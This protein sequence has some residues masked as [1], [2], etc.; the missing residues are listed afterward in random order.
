MSKRILFIV[1]GVLCVMGAKAQTIDIKS[2]EEYSPFVFGHNLEH[3]RAAVN[4]GLSAQMLQNR[5][6]AGKPS[7][8]QGVAG[9]WTGIGGKVFFQQGGHAYTKHICLP[10]M[11]RWNEIGAQ[12]IQN[13]EEGQVAG[14]CQG[15]LF[16]KGGE[17]YELRTVTKVSKPLNLKVELT[18]RE[19]NKVYASKTLSL[20][21]SEDWVVTGFDLTPSK[22]DRDGCVRYTFDKKAEV[23]FGALSMMPKDN[24]H[25]MRP[26]V[27]ANL[28]AIGPRLLR[29][30]GGNFAGEYRW[31]DGLLPVDQRGPLQAVT[32]IETQPYSLGYDYHEIDT[33]DFIALCREVGAEP[34][35]T[36]N[37]SWNTPEESAQWV[38]YCNGS[39]DTEYGRI[40]AERGHKEP[41]NVKLWSLGN[42]IGY[43]HM[44]GPDGPLAYSEFAGKHADEMLKVT[45]DLEFCSSGPYPSDNWA[46]NSA[47]V[48]ADKV[49]YIS[50]HHYAGGSR[51]FTTDEDVRK[52]YE[53][54]TAS[55]KGNVDIAKRMRASLDATGKRLHISFDE[56]NQWYSWYRPSCVAEGIYAARTMHFYLN[57]TNSLDIPIVC[58]FQ[59]VGEGAILV[60]PEGSTLT[61]N[62]QVFALMKAH[63]DGR[64]CK[65][66][67][68]E[69]YSTAA[70]IKDGVVT[71]TLINDS[72]DTDRE[73]VFNLKGKVLEAKLLS[74][75]EVIPYTFFEESPLEVASSRKAIRATLP[76][77]SVALISVKVQ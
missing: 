2:S 73:F 33:D 51:N 77:H 17:A 61:A 72:F 8:N 11:S 52:S 50:L 46:V 76:P 36:I 29:W 64:I 70:T 15:G 74:S 55:F 16:L 37:I 75:E 10:S 67:D 48:L 21:P 5:K 60:T 30:P 63:Q 65:V 18:D 6:F 28:K 59:P 68:N 9:Q 41:Y 34:M 53:E 43:R 13:L 58:Y 62:G 38:E 45:P 54:I 3:T 44:E 4:T 57:E 35:L 24:F 32:E 23:A 26:D 19:G 71:I 49:E 56:W 47:A 42:E 27:V 1:L 40:R 31:K 25:G 12:Y 22:G 20:E 7:K 14:I 69:D 39:T 66:A